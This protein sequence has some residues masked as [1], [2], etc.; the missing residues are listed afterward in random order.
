MVRLGNCKSSV[1][2]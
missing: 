1:F 2:A